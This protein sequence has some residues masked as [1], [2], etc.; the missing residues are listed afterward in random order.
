MIQMRMASQIADIRK[1]LFGHKMDAGITSRYIEI[2]LDETVVTLHQTKSINAANTDEE[3][4]HKGNLREIVKWSNIH[5]DGHLASAKSLESIHHFFNHLTHALP[6]FKRERFS[7][8]AN[9]QASLRGAVRFAAQARRGGMRFSVERT[10]HRTVYRT[11][12]RPVY[13]TGRTNRRPPSWKK[14]REGSP[15]QAWLVLCYP[16]SRLFNLGH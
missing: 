5:Y 1:K 14:Q 11:D 7:H 12:H 6:A 13:R 9:G 16:H 15:Q 10:G 8:D 3:Q 2:V 4:R